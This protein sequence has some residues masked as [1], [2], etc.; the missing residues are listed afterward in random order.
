MTW[1]RPSR[2]LLSAWI[3]FNDDGDWSDPG[4]QVFQD[5]LLA[6]GTNELSFAV[7]S[8]AVAADTFARFR[9]STQSGL[10][11]TGLAPDGEVE[12]FGVTIT[13]GTPPMVESVVVGDGSDAR[14]M[15]SQVVIT[16]DQLMVLDAGVFSV[17]QRGAGGGSVDVAFTTT[18][19]GGKTV[20]TLT[21]SGA[22]TQNG[23]LADGNY[24][25]T[26]DA[27]KAHSAGDVALDGDG[28]GLAGGDYVFGAE[29]ADAFFRLFGDL[30][31]SRFVGNNDYAAFRTRFARPLAMPATIPQFDSDNSAFIG[32]NDY[33]LFR[34]HFRVGL[35]FE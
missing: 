35:P 18:E 26:I 30:D 16:F 1:S 22:F 4:E 15:V 32:N 9:L 2:D 11:F 25:L 33:A 20:A 8:D 28:D 19:V 29:E 21:F 31:G 5:L 12:D 23:S 10:A 34:L 27:T 13:E 17:M 3:D 14:S 6:A 24:D 7:P